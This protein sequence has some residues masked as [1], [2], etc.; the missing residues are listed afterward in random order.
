MRALDVPLRNELSGQLDSFKYARCP[1]PKAS[2]ASAFS[3][4]HQIQSLALRAGG[5]V[6]T[7]MALILALTLSVLSV[8]PADTRWGEAYCEGEGCPTRYMIEGFEV[9]VS[10]SL[11]DNPAFSYSYLGRYLDT[12]QAQLLYMGSEGVVPDA[13]MNALRDSGLTIYIEDPGNQKE[14][15][16][17]RTEQRGCY[18]PDRNRIGASFWGNGGNVMTGW[19]W[20]SFILHE[21]AHAYHFKVIFNGY[22]NRCILDAYNRNK[23]RYWRVEDSSA[24]SGIPPHEGVHIVQHWA[25]NDQMEYFAELSEA[26]FFRGVYYPWNRIELY[27]HDPDGYHMVREAW[28]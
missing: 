14:W 24:H 4:G 21:A 20:Q 28:K 15:W 18:G 10:P 6:M 25:Y 19:H 3:I 13:A 1:I 12:I 11:E 7:R 17:C 16:P 27:R 5:R 22:N 9:W 2:A 23:H 8:V 26:Y